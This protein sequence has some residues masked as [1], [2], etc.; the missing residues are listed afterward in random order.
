MHRTIL[1]RTTGEPE[2]TEGVLVV[3]MTT[4]SGVFAVG[5]VVTGAKTVVYAVEGAKKAAY[6]MMRYMEQDS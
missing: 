4:R 5:D 2:F 3:D 1:A 6:A